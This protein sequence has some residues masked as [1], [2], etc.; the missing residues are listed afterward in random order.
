MSILN[1]FFAK[2]LIF[3]AIFFCS[4]PLVT[5]SQVNYSKPLKGKEL[6]IGN[7]LEWSTSSESNSKIFIVEKSKDGTNFI[8]VGTVDGAINSDEDKNYK[9]L[10]FEQ[11]TAYYRLK[12]VGQNGNFNYTEPIVI[13]KKIPNDFMVVAMNDDINTANVF[14]LTL[15]AWIEGEIKYSVTKKDG[16]FILEG[17]QWLQIGLNELQINIPSE[18]DG[19]YKLA[20]ILGKEEEMIVLKRDASKTEALKFAKKN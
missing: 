14:E 9:Y 4:Y 15:E 10:D 1:R 11:T 7:L 16:E 19:T 13:N 5:L 20:L 8:D 2:P 17:S 6:E 18:V 3:A 12:E